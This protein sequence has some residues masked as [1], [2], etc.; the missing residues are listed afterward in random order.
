MNAAATTPP[1]IVAIGETLWDLLPDG[2]VWG[3][4][5]GNVACHAAGLGAAGAIVSRVGRDDLGDR[6][7]ATLESFGVDCRHVHRDEARPTGTV[8]VSLSP[9][10][11]ASYEFAADVAWDHLA[12]EP[13]LAA[14]AADAAAVCFGTL[15]QR[16]AVSRQTIRRFLAAARGLRVFDVNLRQQFHSPELI[17]ESLALADVLKLNDEEL[18]VVAAAC[19]IAAADPVAALRDLAARHALRLAAL[20]RGKAGSVLVAA[21]QTSLKPARATTIVDTVGAGDAFT[22]AA[23]VGLLRDDPLEAIHDHAARLAAFVCGH[24]GATPAIPATLRA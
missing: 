4:A 19:G 14:V 21:G 20:T 13:S 5:P 1:R 12:W 16:S 24:R 6:G 3:G 7:I 17:R 18:P 8:A 15:G 11:D 23:I 10:G 2:P 22:A 9:A